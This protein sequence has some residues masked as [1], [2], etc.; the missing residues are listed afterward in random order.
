MEGTDG[1]GHAM[2]V[3]RNSKIEETNRKFQNAKHKKKHNRDR[4]TICGRLDGMLST[5]SYQIAPNFDPDTGF[6]AVPAI[7]LY[8]GHIEIPH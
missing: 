8:Q 5:P 2:C 7:F 1:W 6:P 4:R 3:S